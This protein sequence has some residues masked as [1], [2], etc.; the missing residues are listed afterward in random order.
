M[1]ATEVLAWKSKDYAMKMNEGLKHCPFCGSP[2]VVTVR[3]SIDKR[4]IECIT[5]GASTMWFVR[6]EDAQKAWNRRDGCKSD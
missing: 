5:C 6:F 4:R 2:E 1:L 3:S